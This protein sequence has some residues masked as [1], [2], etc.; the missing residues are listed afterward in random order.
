MRR[1]LVMLVGD[2]LGMTV[3]GHDGTV[4]VSLDEMAYRTQCVACG[5][6]NA[7]IVGD[8]PFGSHQESA[9]QALRSASRLMQSGAQMVKL[10]GG[11]TAPTGQFLVERGIPACA[12]L[13]LT[14]QSVHALGGYRVQGRDQQAGQKL[15]QHARELAQAGASMLVV[16]LIPSALAHEVTAALPIPVIGIGAGAGCGG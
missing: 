14:P 1:A 5:N 12:H 9:Q 13:G 2:S 3:Q 4:P 7:W 8:L 15:L 6:R 11:W 10:E 16:E